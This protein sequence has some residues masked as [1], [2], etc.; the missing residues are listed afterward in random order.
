M[1]LLPLLALLPPPPL[2]LGLGFQARP[3]APTL[4]L[5]QQ[6][7][8]QQDLAVGLALQA[9]ALHHLLC[10]H[11]A[12]H[13]RQLQQLHPTCLAVARLQVTLQTRQTA[14]LQW[15]LLVHSAA[16]LQQGAGAADSW[17]AVAPCIPCCLQVFVSNSFERAET[18]RM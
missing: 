2:Q 1:A 6:Q 8:Q 16:A 3:L 11:L 7:Q 10:R 17:F 4:V 5:L 18:C 13:P 12:V 9:L 15:V 14:G